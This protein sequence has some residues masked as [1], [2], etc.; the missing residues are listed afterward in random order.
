M[1]YLSEVVAAGGLA[2]FCTAFGASV[3]PK[4]TNLDGAAIWGVVLAGTAAEASVFPL[5]IVCFEIGAFTS[6]APA[7]FFMTMADAS[8]CCVSAFVWLFI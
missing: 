8:F 6:V 3:W 4:V 2:G 7:V 5:V 1:P